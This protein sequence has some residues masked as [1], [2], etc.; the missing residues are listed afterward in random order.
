[1]LA[2][3]KKVEVTG[4]WKEFTTRTGEKIRFFVP[5]GTKR[6]R[7]YCPTCK[8]TFAVC[9]Y[10]EHLRI[11]HHFYCS[12]RCK[13][14][15]SRGCP[16]LRNEI[17]PPGC[18]TMVGRHRTC[19][20]C[21]NFSKRIVNPNQPNLGVCTAFPNTYVWKDSHYADECP[22]YVNRTHKNR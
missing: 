15:I 6:K 9:P 18:G 17:P 8:T 7:R 1:M 19:G 14:T 16:Y 13:A 11:V 20:S 3:Q 2:A 12:N 21:V 22:K 10:E 5:L 4:G